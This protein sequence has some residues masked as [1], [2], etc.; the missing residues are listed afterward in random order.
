MIRIVKGL[1][2]VADFHIK[3]KIN[4]HGEREYTCMVPCSRGGAN[5]VIGA[6]AAGLRR[7]PLW[8]VG[9]LRGSGPVP[10]GKL[11]AADAAQARPECQRPRSDPHVPWLTAVAGGRQRPG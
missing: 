2:E 5:E 8:L 3:W 9:S 1:T 7:E 11:G 10:G 6:H 4:R